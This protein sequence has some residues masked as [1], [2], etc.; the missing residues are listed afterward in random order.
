MET[1][2]WTLVII[3]AFAAYMFALLYNR[4][5]DAVQK[6]VM[7]VLMIVMLL[8]IAGYAC[9]IDP[10]DRVGPY[11]RWVAQELEHLAV[12]FLGMRLLWRERLSCK[13]LYQRSRLS[14]GS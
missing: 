9:G 4:A 11:I 2:P 13:N 3:H 8:M 1:W 14:L 12:L 10:A 6:T 7:G 5:P